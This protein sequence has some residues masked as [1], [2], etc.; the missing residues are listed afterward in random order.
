MLNYASVNGLLKNPNDGRTEG[1]VF[2]DKVSN[3]EYKVKAK[4]VVNCTGSFADSIRKM[5][6]PSC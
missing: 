1:V 5:D 3:K 6:D 4:C 2:V